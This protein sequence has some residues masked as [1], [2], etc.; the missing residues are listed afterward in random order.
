MALTVL[1]FSKPFMVARLHERIR[2]GTHPFVLISRSAIYGCCGKYMK[3]LCD[4]ISQD[5]IACVI[6]R[7]IGRSIE[8]TALRSM[9][10]A[11]IGYA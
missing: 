11:H 1:P 3:R 4:L 8:M 2:I 5:M 9:R 6:D 10:A 7:A